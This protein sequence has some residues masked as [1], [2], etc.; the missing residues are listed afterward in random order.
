[1]IEYIE[2][3]W[4]TDRIH[5][6]EISDDNTTGMGYRKGSTTSPFYAC[7]KSIGN[8]VKQNTLYPSMDEEDMQ[9]PMAAEN[10][11]GTVVCFKD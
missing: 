9:M 3:A 8:S 10:Y 5:Y 6:L 1:M 11:N 4:E 2:D 7:V